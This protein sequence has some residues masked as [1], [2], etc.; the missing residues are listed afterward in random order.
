MF[1]LIFVAYEN[2]LEKHTFKTVLAHDYTVPTKLSN[3]S[4]LI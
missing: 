4:R 1:N 3:N 2:H